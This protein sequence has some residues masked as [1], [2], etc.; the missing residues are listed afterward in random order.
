MR[1]TTR[2][3]SGDEYIDY[4]SQDSFL[5]G[6]QTALEWWCQDTQTT[7]WPKLSRMAIDIL[8]IL[9]VSDKPKRVFSGCRRTIQWDRGQLEP[10][11]IKWRECL[12]QW[13]KSKILDVFIEDTDLEAM[14][15]T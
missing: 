6:A 3:A 11:T 5:L 4:N 14:L 8:S 15:D 13:K 9:P 1:T 10:E 2:P 12:K 7:R